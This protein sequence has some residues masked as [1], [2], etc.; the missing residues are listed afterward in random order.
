MKPLIKIL[1]CGILLCLLYVIPASADE[2]YDCGHTVNIDLPGGREVTL[3]NNE[4]S[5]C[6]TYDEVLDLVETDT[7]N[8]NQYVLGSYDC[9]D[10]SRDLHNV[11]EKVGIKCTYVVIH[12]EHQAH[13][14]CM[15]PLDDGS[16]LFIEPQSDGIARVE[17]GEPYQVWEVGDNDCIFELPEV[18]ST[19]FYE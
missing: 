6:G 8:E 18:I 4:D 5:H 16:N 2:I 1:T 19:D 12:F 14:L 15:F 17:D 9:G 10:F 7:T 3:I 11:A 13:V